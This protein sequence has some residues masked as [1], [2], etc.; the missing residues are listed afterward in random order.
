MD[1]DALGTA[2]SK[3][4]YNYMHGIGLEQDVS[5]WFTGPVPATNVPQTYVANAL[6]QD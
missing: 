3:A 4:I 6:A 2:L 5:T 1:H